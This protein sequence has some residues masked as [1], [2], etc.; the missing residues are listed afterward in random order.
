MEPGFVPDHS[1]DGVGDT[2]DSAHFAYPVKKRCPVGFETPVTQLKETVQYHYVG[3]PALLVLSSDA[4]DGTDRGQS[5]H[6]DYIQSWDLVAFQTLLDNC[7]TPT[8]NVAKA[9]CG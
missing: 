5:L 3:D 1:A 8:R 7:V 4:A 2:Q 9:A 6:A